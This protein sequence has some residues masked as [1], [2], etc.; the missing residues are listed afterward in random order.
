[1]AT[2]HSQAL[3]LGID[4]GGSKCRALIVNAKGERLGEGCGGPANPYQDFQQ[5]VDSVSVATQL[6]LR[7]AGLDPSASPRLHACLG[8]AGVN[9]PAVHQAFMQWQHPYGRLL[10]ATDLRVACIGAHGGGDGAV[11][12]AGTGS[13]GYAHVG[14]H[15]VF[16]GAHGFPAGDKG[17][18]AWLGLQA[19]QH[20]LLALDGFAEP[21]ALTD[22]LLAQLKARDGIGLVEAIGH[23]ASQFAQ[24]APLVIQA[25]NQ[26]DPVATAIVTSGA[27]YISQLAHKLL[28]IKPP[29]LSLIGGLAPLLTPWLDPFVQAQ[30]SPALEQPEMGAVRLAMQTW[31]Q[32]QSGHH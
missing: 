9:I 4:G 24:L 20:V 22:A 26:R 28:A 29:R 12:I 7:D 31:S 23:G 32:S 30:L 2:T 8:L 10:V 19:M 6:A 25:A 13:V 15:E 14:T 5:S 1:M 18:G 17:S 16:Y 3:F 21:T 27:D 11:I